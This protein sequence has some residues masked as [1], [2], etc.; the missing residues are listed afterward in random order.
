MR[1][2][3][4]IDQAIVP[5]LYTEKIFLSTAPGQKNHFPRLHGAAMSAAKS[6]LVTFLLFRNGPQIVDNPD[7]YLTPQGLRRATMVRILIGTQYSVQLPHNMIVL[8]SPQPIAWHTAAAVTGRPMGDFNQM[9][10]IDNFHFTADRTIVDAVDAYA[11][12]R[13]VTQGEA[14][15][16][17]PGQAWIHTRVLAFLK[18]LRIHFRQAIINGSHALAAWMHYGQIDMIYAVLSAMQAGNKPNNTAQVFARLP[19]TPTPH[20]GGY[21]VKLYVDDATGEI[22]AIESI[23]EARFRF[24]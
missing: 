6:T 7:Q 3:V 1:V 9:P 5:V 17:G 2:L 12:E 20:F 4:T 21:I 14:I 15:Y 19:Q 13:N 23:V 22:T 18:A 10:Q 16:K 8:T 11:A 24:T